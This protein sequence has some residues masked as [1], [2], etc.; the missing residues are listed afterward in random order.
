MLFC[1]NLGQTSEEFKIAVKKTGGIVRFWV[2]NGTNIS[3]PVDCG[4]G[5]LYKSQIALAQER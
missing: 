3:Q 2:Q 1:D 5:Q 4:Y